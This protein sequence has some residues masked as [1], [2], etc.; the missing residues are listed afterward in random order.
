MAVDFRDHNYSF[1]HFIR[2]VMKS[3]AYQLSSQF[4]G[5]WQEAYVPYYARKYVRMLS[6]A[7]H[8]LALCLRR[9]ECVAQPARGEEAP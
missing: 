2:T 6:A 7:E 3:S 4:E 9:A 5:E 8:P 1:K